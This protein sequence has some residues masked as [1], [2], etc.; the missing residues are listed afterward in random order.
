MPAAR[1]A[2][3]TP[4]TSGPSGP[5]TTRSTPSAAAERD[6]SRG[7]GEV[8]RV[9]R[10][11]LPRC[12]R[13]RE[14]RAARRR[15]SP[16]R[17]SGRARAHEHRNRARGPSR[18]SSLGDPAAPASPS[19]LV[20]V[21]DELTVE[22]RSSSPGLGAVERGRR[23]ARRRV[24]RVGDAEQRGPRDRRREAAASG[25]PAARCARA[26]PSCTDAVSQSGSVALGGHQQRERDV[27]V[28][29]GL[30]P[31]PGR[32]VRPADL[33]L[34]D[35]RLLHAARYGARGS[36]W[37]ARRRA[38]RRSRPLNGRRPRRAGPTPG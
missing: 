36:G 6:R 19:P 8:E 1:S 30:E 2:S 37:R 26:R 25:S 16:R 38:S 7:V 21:T 13:C 12:R 33:P 29:D 9:R 10:R 27:R 35:D 32:G 4:S 22:R 31:E 15:R 14:R 34:A 11:R 20:R 17:A 5:T 3:A 23:C 24:I 18:A 28:P